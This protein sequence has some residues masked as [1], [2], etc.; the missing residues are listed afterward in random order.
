VVI[1]NDE[2]ESGL[3][4]DHWHEWEITGR[5]RRVVLCIETG[6]ELEPE[7]DGFDPE[8]LEALIEEATRLMR[9]SANPIDMLRII[10][11]EA[12]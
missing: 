12:D 5:E 9:G 10:P 8:L 3:I 2:D 11:T 4:L 1:A 7:R 6:L